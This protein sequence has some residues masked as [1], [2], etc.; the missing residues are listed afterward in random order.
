MKRFSPLMF[1]VCL[2]LSVPGMAYSQ[3]VEP[4]RTIHLVYD[5]SGS[6]I[7]DDQG[8]YL[9][10]WCQARYA[11][12]VVAAM[13]GEK[14]KLDIYYMSGFNNAPQALLGNSGAQKNV[15]EIHQR[16]MQFSNTTP[17]AAVEKAFS[18]FK[19][20]NSD[21][22]LVVLSDG[23]FEDKSVEVVEKRLGDFA[24][25]ENTQVAMLAMGEDGPQISPR[26]SEG[27]FYERA[28]S[29]HILDKLTKISNQIFKR[30]QIDVQPDNTLQFS[31]PLQQII[32]LAQGRDVK[33]NGIV[34][35][36]GARYT[37]SSNVHASADYAEAA[38]GIKHPELVVPCSLNGYVAQFDAAF[39]PGTYKLDITGADSIAAYFKPNVSVAAYLYDYDR[40][41]DKPL[42]DGEKIT[43][44]KYIVKY[45][46][47]AATED[48]TPVK[49]ISLLERDGQKVVYTPKIINKT[50]DGKDNI[51]EFKP[52]KPIDIKEGKL[53]IDVS[54]NFL[55]YTNVS[56]H[57]DYDVH[58]EN[59]L[60]WEV[61][62]SPKYIMTTLGFSN[63]EEP[64]VLN[65]K[66][67]TKDGKT[68]AF[69][70]EEWAQ[71]P[72]TLRVSQVLPDDVR[73][74][75]I[76][77]L[78]EFKS[79]RADEIG[80]YELW[81]SL[82][83]EEA[84]M[85]KSL[86][87]KSFTYEVRADFS[88]AETGSSAHGD[89]TASFDIDDQIST[90]DRFKQLI[91]ENPL[92]STCVALFF[93]FLIGYGPKKRLSRKVWVK[94][95]PP[96]R[97]Q[98]GRAKKAPEIRDTEWGTYKR[99]LW[100]VI[101]PWPLVKRQKA[102]IVFD[103]DIPDAHIEAGESIDDMII[104]NKEEFYDFVPKLKKLDGHISLSWKITK[105]SYNKYYLY[106]A[107]L[108][109]RPPSD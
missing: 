34:A 32:I 37:A 8:V 31:V 54:A 82:A 43:N 17:F 46:L 105:E 94:I 55:K 51:I 63:A 79:K 60:A 9:D 25:A 77:H 49:D 108:T 10:T 95:K 29:K 99:S 90:I 61:T 68:Q 18:S 57:L 73:E 67:R 76:V 83:A 65:V 80:K 93:L 40:D 24:S 69:T 84:D 27:L 16:Q 39:E 96:E 30:H 19:Q 38:Q 7:H 109:M 3:D 75:E 50:V 13:L 48:K 33:I 103:H 47:I 5:D 78:S 26:E 81:T 102:T 42:A 85:R 35:Q 28:D 74:E 87:V 106:T 53:I 72:Q 23:V 70:A 91:R 101:A 62:S 104:V 4:A 44:G 107:Q 14:D 86:D 22:W 6:M 88:S 2:G 45:G 41:A 1:A 97:T 12:E 71:M 100:S 92:A 15:D 21:H 52:G 59:E 66:M 64:I 98:L 36:N 11:M 20:D 56:A 58:Y 89:M